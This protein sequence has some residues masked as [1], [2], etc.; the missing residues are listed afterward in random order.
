MINFYYWNELKKPS[1]FG[2]KNV[3]ALV[4]NNMRTY[5]ADAIASLHYIV[6]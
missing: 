2:S 1:E 6:Q 4:R 3:G 5:P